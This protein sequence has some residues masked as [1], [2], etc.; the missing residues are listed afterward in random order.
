MAR[1]SPP[2]SQQGIVI[3]Q[4]DIDMDSDP[5]DGEYR[6]FAQIAVQKAEPVHGS[7]SSTNEAFP[8]KL[9]FMLS[10]LECEC[11]DSIVGWE[12]HHGR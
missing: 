12:P 1:S 5:V 7:A 2:L 9:H 3:G 8:A 4:S 6:D 11:L 10:V